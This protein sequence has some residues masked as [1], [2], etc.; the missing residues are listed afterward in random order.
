MPYQTKRI[1]SLAVIVAFVAISAILI[2]VLFDNIG[3]EKHKHMIG[4]LGS[5]M[6]LVS[7]VY[8]LRK[9]KILL[10]NG[11]IQSWL[12]GHE[13][14]AIAGTVLIFI[15][16]GFHTH[17]AVPIIT[18]ILLFISFVSGLIGR[19]VYESERERLKGMREWIRGKGMGANEIE[20]TLQPLLEANKKMLRWRSFHIP[21]I[22]ALLLFVVFHI[23]SALY[24]GGF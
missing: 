22:S 13:V 17:A 3:L 6:V 12:K 23:V 9:R 18:L 1:F 5:L 7:F 24:Y 20:E 19:Y 14:L 2:E 10:K 15:H 4:N 11:N 21:L 16:A 8:S